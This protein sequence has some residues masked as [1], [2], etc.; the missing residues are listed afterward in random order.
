MVLPD[1][2]Q[3]LICMRKWV[4]GIDE[5]TFEVIFRRTQ[6]PTTANQTT[7]LSHIQE[8]ESNSKHAK[9]LDDDYRKHVFC[10][11]FLLI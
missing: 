2:I 4:A 11:Q 10:M 6:L 1:N 7:L 9:H 5:L 8:Y 3:G